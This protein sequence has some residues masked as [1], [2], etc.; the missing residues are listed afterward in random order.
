MTEKYKG[1]IT[2]HLKVCGVPSLSEVQS[3]ENS[4][5]YSAFPD[6]HE[7]HC[8]VL[9]MRGSAKLEVMPAGVTDGWVRL[10]SFLLDF[11]GALQMP[12]VQIQHC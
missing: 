5:C 8:F 7:G 11:Q 6:T 3:E 2:L 10:P 4:W 9:V 12:H 1:E